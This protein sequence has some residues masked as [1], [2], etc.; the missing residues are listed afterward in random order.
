MSQ[1]ENQEASITSPHQASSLTRAPKPTFT[2]G[3]HGIR[4]T[5]SVRPKR[6]CGSSNQS[7]AKPYNT[8]RERE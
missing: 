5:H 1:R 8:E 3:A 4:I 7:R 2:F 6:L